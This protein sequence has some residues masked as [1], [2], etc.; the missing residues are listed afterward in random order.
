[1][2]KLANIQRRHDQLHHE[3]RN[4][5]QLG[6]D[7]RISYFIVDALAKAA[8]FGKGRGWARGGRGHVEHAHFIGENV[9]ITKKYVS[10]SLF[11]Y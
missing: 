7:L 3:F 9:L 1:M 5:Y 8:T 11:V 4:S 2:S 6:I 10:A